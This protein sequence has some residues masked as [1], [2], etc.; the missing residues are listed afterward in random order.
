VR[1]FT[2]RSLQE[3]ATASGDFQLVARVGSGFYP[4]TPGPGRILACLWPGGTVYTVVLLRR[5][6]E[7]DP[8]YWSRWASGTEDTRWGCASAD[9]GAMSKEVTR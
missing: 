2:A 3:L 1:G 7:V 6:A 8:G 5:H 4:L 9:G